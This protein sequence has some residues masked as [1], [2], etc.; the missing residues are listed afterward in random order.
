METQAKG[1]VFRWSNA[2]AAVS[3]TL[4][5]SKQEVSFI[6]AVEPDALAAHDE[7]FERTI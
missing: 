2:G 1:L 6:R 3:P 7:V 5:R 4:T